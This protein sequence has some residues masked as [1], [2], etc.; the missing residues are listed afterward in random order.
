MNPH[1]E[2][3]TYGDLIYD[4]FGISSQRKNMNYFINYT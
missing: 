3:N 4:K 2:P 1:I